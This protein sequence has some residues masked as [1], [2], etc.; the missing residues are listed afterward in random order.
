M[1]RKE[2]TIFDVRRNAS[3]FHS[4]DW[5]TLTKIFYKD[6]EAFREKWK[7]TIVRTRANSSNI[8]LYLKCK[9][10]NCS[11]QYK[12]KVPKISNNTKNKNSNQV[13][14]IDH[15]KLNEEIEIMMKFDHDHTTNELNSIKSY[16]IKE[17]VKDFILPMIANKTNPK[18]VERMLKDYAAQGQ[19]KEIDLPTIKQLQDFKRNQ[20]R[21]EIF[22]GTEEEFRE[23]IEKFNPNK[24]HHENETIII[25]YNIN[26]EDFCLVF[27]S[28]LLLNNIIHQASAGP[29]RYI[30][31]DGTYKLTVLGYP[32]VVVGTQDLN[33]K[34]RLI[35]IALVRH[36]REEDYKFILE[37]IK[38]AVQK[39]FSY[40]WIVDFVMSDGCQAIL[41][42]SRSIFGETYIHGMCSVHMW[43]NVEK[44]I[45]S[46]VK[47]EDRA[48]LKEDLKILENLHSITLFQNALFLFEKKWDQN[49]SDF[50]NYFYENW[51][52][53]DFSNWYRGSIPVGFSHTNNAVEGFNNG[54]KLKYTNWERLQ[55]NDFFKVV[56]E[57]INDYSEQS[58][59]LPF[60]KS[61]IIEKC[62]WKKAQ[63]MENDPYLQEDTTFYWTKLNGAQNSARKK[64]LKSM[65]TKY[66]N[67]NRCQ[68]FDKFK[69][70]NCLWMIKIGQNIKSTSC[71]CPK[72]MLYY[73]CKHIIVAMLKLKLIEVPIEFSTKKIVSKKN[74]P[75]RN[76]KAQKITKKK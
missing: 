49:G 73:V 72:F 61:L 8:T 28:R 41:N 60:S 46:L 23:L 76:P 22:I 15:T 52:N 12:T 53:S 14:D 18:K 11:V 13:D 10:E 38:S 50:L 64:V 57:I 31:L 74:K 43:R 33:H 66:T 20:G 69:E 37:S 68:S 3:N 5:T 2:T 35:A 63:S 16:G 47:V 75:G 4:E 34:F 21:K 67:L 9:L 54:I 19:F 24:K 36:E 56:E 30:C 58:L 65:V 70:T 6:L 29:T 32:L 42:A 1:S 40:D 17:N 48:D 62:L 7:M 71:S 44:K 26:P 45:T 51:V 39:F 59:A 55:L 25:G 27:S